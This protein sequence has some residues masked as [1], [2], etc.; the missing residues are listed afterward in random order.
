MLGC[1]MLYYVAALLCVV[2]SCVVSSCVEV[3]QRCVVQ[4]AHSP[5]HVGALHLAA[6]LNFK[7]CSDV[8]AEHLV[9]LL[10]DW[11]TTADHFTR[12]TEGVFSVDD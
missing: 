1:A 12:F 4:G 7:V 3:G 2:S 6:A 5:L 11:W 9:R 10:I 8:V